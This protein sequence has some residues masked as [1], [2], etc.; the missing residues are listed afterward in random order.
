MCLFE[1]EISGLLPIEKEKPFQIILMLR[2]CYRLTAPYLFLK[3]LAICACV[4]TKL[5]V[6]HSR[7]EHVNKKAVDSSIN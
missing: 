5:T 3:E 4:E 2:D 6:L 1:C 7:E